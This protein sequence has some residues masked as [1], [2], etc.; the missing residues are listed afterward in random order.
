MPCHIT[1]LR[2]ME[3]RMAWQLHILPAIYQ[4]HLD[5]WHGELM[6][7]LQSITRWSYENASGDIRSYLRQIGAPDTFESVGVSVSE[8]FNEMRQSVNNERLQNNPIDLN[9]IELEQLLK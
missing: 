9:F 6:D 3:Y 4:F 1:L 5:N 7:T 8:V 2:S